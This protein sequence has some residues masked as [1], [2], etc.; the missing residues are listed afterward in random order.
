MKMEKRGKSS[1]NRI[2]KNLAL[3]ILILSVSV[4]CAPIGYARA[5]ELSE[6]TEIDAT[7]FRGNTGISTIH[8]GSN[9]T[10][11]SS[12]S[13]RGLMNLRSITVS[14][15]NPYYAS[16]SNCLYDK[17]L[18]QL[19]CYPPA[20]SGAVI[21]DSVVAIGENALYGVPD[22][23]KSQIRAVV[24]AQSQGGSTEKPKDTENSTG[25][26]SGSAQNSTGQPSGSAQQTTGSSTAQQKSQ[27]TEKL[28]KDMSGPRFVHTSTG[29]KWK[30]ADGTTKEPDTELMGLVAG[31]IETCTTADMTAST[32]LQ[33]CFDYFVKTTSYKKRIEVPLGNWA[34]GY[35]T[36]ILKKGEGNMYNYA[37]AF[38]YIASGLGYESRICTGA[39]ESAGGNRSG[40]AWTEVLIDGEWYIFDAQMQRLNGQGY[41]QQTYA[42]YP[43]GTLV[44]DV[45]YSV[46]Y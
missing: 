20:L 28:E 10:D 35:A 30:N 17:N 26:P 40:R 27:K 24:S 29:V 5:S 3:T 39:V 41:Y 6:I 21:P 33:R 1:F 18:T 44:S 15:N 37:A 38:A 42:G 32:Q 13:F 46:T 8:I 23:V 22:N 19:L 12:G 36:E 2:K 14:E 34:A 31:L 7:T 43:D 4:L 45:S 9:V 25:Q 11:I 16:Y